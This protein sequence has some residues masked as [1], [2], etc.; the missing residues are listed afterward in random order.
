MFGDIVAFLS[1]EKL[2]RVNMMNGNLYL[3]VQKT[4]KDYANLKSLRKNVFQSTLAAV[5]RGEYM[6]AHG[7]IVK[8]LATLGL[9]K[10]YEAE[11]LRR[12]KHLFDVNRNFE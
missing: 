11:S 2:Y 8:E 9:P 12:K 3:K 7:H 4:H 1:M 6:T 10:D 5:K